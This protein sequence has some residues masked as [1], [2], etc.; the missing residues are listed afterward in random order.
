MY[1][2]NRKIWGRNREFTLTIVVLARTL[3]CRDE[4]RHELRLS[5][6]R[7]ELQ[8]FVRALRGPGRK[9]GTS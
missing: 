3:D 6:H 2:G 7:L 9:Y 8:D 4:E 1:A 5:V